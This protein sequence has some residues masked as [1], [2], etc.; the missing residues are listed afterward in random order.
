M[1][2]DHGK[3]VWNFCHVQTDSDGPKRW[4]EVPRL[5]SFYF[6]FR[7]YNI[8]DSQKTIQYVST[9]FLYPIKIFY[10][11]FTITSNH[12]TIAWNFLNVVRGHR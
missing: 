2:P 6:I 7:I 10:F 1:A 9:I 3:F 4:E 11:I 5:K 12:R 8:F